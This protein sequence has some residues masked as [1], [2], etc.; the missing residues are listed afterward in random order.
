[1]ARSF[2]QMDRKIKTS[3]AKHIHLY[4]AFEGTPLWRRVDKAI[5]ALVKNGDLQETM[6]REY[7]VGYIC[8][9]VSADKAQGKRQGN[10]E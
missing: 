1:M 6:S 5:S 2:G 7:I 4:I 3:S 9:I 10:R 8:K